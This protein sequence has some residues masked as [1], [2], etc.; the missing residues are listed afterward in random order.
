MLPSE[1]EIVRPRPS[2]IGF[3]PFTFDRANGLLRQG[4]RELPLPPRVLGVLDLLVSRAG[5]IVPKQ[6][7]IDGVWKEAFVTDT[8]LAEAISVLRQALGDNPQAPNYVQTVHRRGYRFVAPVT[9][10]GPAT[11][12]IESVPRAASNVERVSPSI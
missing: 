1:V 7:I 3:G 9:L 8:S 10:V 2:M 5:E 11:P 12:A 4:A 6:E